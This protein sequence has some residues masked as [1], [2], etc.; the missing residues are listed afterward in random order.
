MRKPDHEIFQFVLDDSRLIASETLYIDD[1][2]KHVKAARDLGIKGHHLH[3][4][5]SI[6]EIL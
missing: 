4:P 1:T 2:E 3:L 6:T 5:Q